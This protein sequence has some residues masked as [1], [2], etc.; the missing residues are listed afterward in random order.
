MPLRRKRK[1]KHTVEDLTNLIY[2]LKR[3]IEEIEYELK[4]LISALKV[5]EEIVEKTKGK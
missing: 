1:P 2:Y 4:M 5:L 3:K